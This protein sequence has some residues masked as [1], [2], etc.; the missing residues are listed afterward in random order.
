[1]RLKK[2][3]RRPRHQQAD[4]RYSVLEKRAG[5]R[6]GNWVAR[7]T[8]GLAPRMKRIAQIATIVQM[9][10]ITVKALISV[11]RSSILRQG[12]CGLTASRGA[13]RAS[14]PR[15]STATGCS[16]RTWMRPAGQLRTADF[17]GDGKTSQAPCAIGTIPVC[18]D[19]REPN[20]LKRSKFFELFASHRK[21]EDFSKNGGR[22]ARG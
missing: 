2:R 7:S 18:A 13:D 1:V 15:R 11:F 17:C 4:R 22:V 19:E 21:G 10:R 16:S 6:C 12:L 5:R 9:Q 8:P 20:P 14:C 3:S